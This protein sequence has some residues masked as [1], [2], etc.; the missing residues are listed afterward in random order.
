M[1]SQQVKMNKYFEHDTILNGILTVEEMGFIFMGWVMYQHD[2]K[3]EKSYNDFQRKKRTIE[4]RA[5]I[6]ALL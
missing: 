6:R 3:D 5:L 2:R 1:T 4:G